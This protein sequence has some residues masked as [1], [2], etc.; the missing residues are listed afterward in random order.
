MAIC[1]RHVFCM[2]VRPDN[3]PGDNDY[4]DEEEGDDDD[5]EGEDDEED[6]Y[7]KDTTINEVIYRVIRKEWKK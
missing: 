1:A 7:L 5:D 2:R 6:E 4:G 3:L